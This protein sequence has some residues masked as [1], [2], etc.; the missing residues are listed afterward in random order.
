M[1]IGQNAIWLYR[2]NHGVMVRVLVGDKALPSTALQLN[3]GQ[4]HHIAWRW[5]PFQID[6]SLDDNIVGRRQGQGLLRPEASPSTT[7]EF[8]V[9]SSSPFCE[10]AIDW[11][12]IWTIAHLEVFLKSMYYI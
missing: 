10:F 3:N 4:W 6:I 8:N 1:T 12:S 2:M 7:V 11:V 5:F 9:Q